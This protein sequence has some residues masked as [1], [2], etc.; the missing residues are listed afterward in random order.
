MPDLIWAVAC[1]RVITDVESNK[2]TL[3]DVLENVTL[4]TE[5]DHFEEELRRALEAGKKP[6][7]EAPLIVIAF[8]VRSNL[9][10]AE[11]GQARLRAVAPDGSELVMGVD[12]N[13]TDYTRLRTKLIV[14]RLPWGGEGV[15][16]LNVERLDAPDKWSTL[17]RIPVG[18]DVSFGQPRD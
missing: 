17:A 7:V 6:M 14:N 10:E 1:E 2:V 11:I 5:R 9:D 8:W 15:V 4:R 13:L 18:L 3:V 12:V 16:W